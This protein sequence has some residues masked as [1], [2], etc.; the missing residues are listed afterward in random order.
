MAVM[1]VFGH[2]ALTHNL[3]L[4]ALQLDDLAHVTV[5]HDSAIASEFLFDDRK[6]L[7]AIKLVG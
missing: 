7:L 4:V 2:E 1:N 5:H 6:N 3:A